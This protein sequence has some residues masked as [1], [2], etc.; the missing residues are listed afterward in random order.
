M[1][2]VINTLSAL[3]GGGQVY[4]YNLLK[5]AKEFPGVRIYVLAPPEFVNYYNFQGVDITP[6]VA[7]SKSII[8]RN[9]FERWKL[10]GLLKNLKADILFCPGGIINTSPPLGCLTATTFQNMLIFDTS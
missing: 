3:W 9:F 7:A 1:N 2:L 5:Y 4:L 6:C 8:H 10:P